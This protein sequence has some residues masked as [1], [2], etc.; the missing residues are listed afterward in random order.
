MVS[1]SKS[2]GSKVIAAVVALLAIAFIADFLIGQAINAEVRTAT[3]EL[4]DH[5]TESL[6]EKDAAIGKML[7]E[8]QTLQQTN[9]DLKGQVEQADINAGTLGEE[10]H[11]AGVRDG[12]SSVAATLIN[13]SM[14]GGEA[15][16]VETIVETLLEDPTI[17]NIN[18]WRIDGTL[19]FRDNETIRAVNDI[20]G[21]GSFD[22]RRTNA[23]ILI[24]DARRTAFD[25][26]V[27][28]K[29]GEEA[30]FRGDAETDDGTKSA[31]YSYFVL[32]NGEDC[33]ACHGE[34][35]IPR[36]VIELALSRAQLDAIEAESAEK[37]AAFEAARDKADAALKEEITNAL[38]AMEAEAAREAKEVAT[39]S[40]ALDAQQSAATTWSVTAKIAF[41]VATA[42]VLAFLMRAML[43]RPLSSMTGAMTRLA[44]NDLTV[45]IPAQDRVDEIGAM[46]AAVQVFKDNAVKVQKLAA[47][48]EQM[49]RQADSERRALLESLADDFESSVSSLVNSLS[50]SADDMRTESGSMA[51]ATQLAGV[52]ASSILDSA[53]T[54]A[55]NVRE[56]SEAADALSRSISHISGQVAQS[57]QIS[58][59]AVAEAQQTNDT[60]VGLADAAN[61]IGE[62]VALINDIAEQTNLLALNATIEAA[63]AGEAGKGFAVVASEVKNLADQTAKATEEITTQIQGIQG[64]TN[65]TVKAIQSIASTINRI[66]EIA[67]EI[68]TA[69][70][71]Q[72]NAIQAIANNAEQAAEGTRAVTDTVGEVAQ[73]VSATSDSAQNV[74]RASDGLR[75]QAGGLRKHVDNFLRHVRTG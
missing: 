15:S 60:V 13:T 48:Q 30:Q 22:F 4:S 62:V 25:A 41:V 56:V 33:Q 70:D 24:P 75:E 55:I 2:L 27:A 14:L 28:G 42:I 73:T 63:R 43:G 51:E 1:W 17:L 9:L 61:R 40:E 26:A 20:V 46:A 6:T 45:T 59:E 67:S 71:E 36:G 74:L 52:R 29:T 57:T 8:S 53:E 23:P 34:N 5:L 64:A 49:A 54:A 11:I 10:A 44:D 47:E 32:P 50:G 38:A 37:M 31:I 39:A 21:E 18:L 19:A 72:G 66:N 12:I 7:A 35:D 16:D 68:S 65:G 3:T 69:V 58:S